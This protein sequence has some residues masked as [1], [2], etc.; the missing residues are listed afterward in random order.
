MWGG[1]L[2]CARFFARPARITA[3]PGGTFTMPADLFEGGECVLVQA[4]ATAE[5]GVRI[6]Q[7][8]VGG[9]LV[10]DGEV[11][12][13]DDIKRG[14]MPA[15]EGPVVPLTAGTRAV[16]RFGEFTFVVG[17]LPVPPP[18]RRSLWTPDLMPLALCLLLAALLTTGPLSVAWMSPDKL[19]V[20]RPTLA[21]NTPARHAPMILVEPVLPE[22]PK[23][24]AAVPLVPQH[25]LP[26]RPVRVTPPRSAE[27]DEADRLAS[28]LDA[29]PEEERIKR[30]DELVTA[31]IDELTPLLEDLVPGQLP[32]MLFDEDE[33]GQPRHVA[34]G[35]DP[36]LLGLPTVPGG[37]DLATDAEPVDEPSDDSVRPV[38]VPDLGKMRDVHRTRVKIGPRRG[39]GVVKI[40]R[41]SKKGALSR[42]AIRRPNAARIG[43]IRAC[44][45]KG[46][47]RDSDLRGRLLVRFIIGPDG[48][49]AG[50]RLADDDLGDAEVAACVLSIVRT[51]R[52]PRVVGGEST[53]VK[54]P[55]ELRRR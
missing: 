17:R 9:H 27:A 8:R 35:I 1:D 12:D 15:L 37:V 54:Y 20:A 24:A 33:A 44:Y 22:P 31:R 47:Q 41:P 52:F 19:A 14:Y 38:D 45:Q 13:L 18:A 49:V 16:L 53:T 28:E 23:Q 2:L 11:F 36:T 40:P 25:L 43:A 42:E 10:V 5:F 34:G 46:L 39:E 26:P 30:A 48:V 3:G 21:E 29:L 7:P 55:F 32:L 4:H 6:D 50:A 51:T